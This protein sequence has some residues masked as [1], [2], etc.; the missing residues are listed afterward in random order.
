M[1]GFSSNFH[2]Y[3]KLRTNSTDD[4]AATPPTSSDKAIP[5][6]VFRTLARY[7][8]RLGGSTVVI[9]QCASLVGFQLLLSIFNQIQHD[10]FSAAWPILCIAV[11]LHRPVTP[12]AENNR[13]M[14]WA[15]NSLHPTTTGKLYVCQHLSHHSATSGSYFALFRSIASLHI[16]SQGT[17]NSMIMI[18]C[19]VLY[20]FIGTICLGT[21]NN[22][23][24]KSTPS[25]QSL[26]SYKI[27]D[28]LYS[29]FCLDV[30]VPNSFTNGI[31]TGF[32]F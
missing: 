13:H 1:V 12:N 32:F 20:M 9:N 18:F 2:I 25:C 8:L 6:C 24:S 3:Y 22:F 19:Q 4:V 7:T 23:L 14:D 27:P 31:C 15:G 5:H 10:D 26:A 16:S 30:V 17:V 11:L 28:L 29:R 21:L